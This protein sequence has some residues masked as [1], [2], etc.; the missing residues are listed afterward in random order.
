MIPTSYHKIAPRNSGAE[1]DEALLRRLGQSTIVTICRDALPVW[2]AVLALALMG[3]RVF[4]AMAR[5]AHMGI[6]ALLLAL[7]ALNIGFVCGAWWKGR[8]Q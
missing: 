8:F 4:Y 3:L 1:A 6:A 2:F 5:G 7:L